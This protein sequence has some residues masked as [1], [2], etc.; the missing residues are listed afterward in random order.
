MASKL[1]NK[2]IKKLHKKQTT[3]V[4]KGESLIDIIFISTL[5]M[6]LLGGIISGIIYPNLEHIST[7]ILLLL[8]GA[9]VILIIFT[10]SSCGL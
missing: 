4:N 6:L 5:F 10:N 3:K 8:G 9:I 7:G 1:I 2:K